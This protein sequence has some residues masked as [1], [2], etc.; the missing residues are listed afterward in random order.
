MRVHTHSA[1]M[2]GWI[3]VTPNWCKFFSLTHR[4]NSY[5]VQVFTIAQFE[6]VFFFLLSSIRQ[7]LRILIPAVRMRGEKMVPR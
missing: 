6:G 7:L 2:V 1:I 3:M 4:L 5:V